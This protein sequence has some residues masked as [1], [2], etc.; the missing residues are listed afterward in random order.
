ML[1]LIIF[2]NL[3]FEKNKLLRIVRSSLLELPSSILIRYTCKFLPLVIISLVLQIARGLLLALSYNCDIGT[4]FFRVD[5]IMRELPR[6]GWLFRSI[7]SNGASIFFVFIYLHIARGLYYRSFN[8]SHVWLIGCSILLVT[9]GAAFLGYVLPWGQIRFWGASVITGLIRVL[10]AGEGILNGLWGGSSLDSTALTRFFTL[11]FLLPFILI[12]MRG[13]HLFFLHLRGSRNPIG[14][15]L[16]RDKLKFNPYFSWKD[17]IGFV[18]TIHIMLALVIFNPWLLGDP[19]NFIQAN[20]LITPIHIQPEWYFLFAYAI[21]RSIPNKIGGVIA[22]GASVI[23]YYIM[24]FL[25]HSN[26]KSKIFMP[27]NKLLFWILVSIILLLTWVG[28]RPVENPYIFTGQLLTIS[29][30][31][32]FLIDLIFIKI[33]SSRI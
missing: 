9:I 11:H 16:D 1:K 21:L 12:G 31:S 13:L 18:F 24:P 28:A 30:F 32:W 8:L 14:L 20:S 26:S 25:G 6:C 33:W 27:F 23:I 29:Y 19:E 17:L 2:I 3:V 4:A 22:L 15:K 10:P 7:H 5:A